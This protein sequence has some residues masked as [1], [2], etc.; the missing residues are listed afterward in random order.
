MRRVLAL[1]LFGLP[2]FA[3]AFLPGTEAA[4]QGDD[5]KRAL[6]LYARHCAVCH[7]DDGRG[8]GSAAYLLNPRPRDFGRGEFRLITTTNGAPTDEDLL[9]VITNGMPGSAMPPWDRLPES[10][11]RL[12]V[13]VVKDLWIKALRKAYEGDE[14]AEE[15]IRQDTTPGT[16]VSYEGEGEPDLSRI[17]LGRIVY[18]QACA[19]CHGLDG[20]GDSTKELLDSQKNP[21]PARDF[22]KGIFKGG[23]EARQVYARLRAGMKGTAMPTFEESMLSQKEAWA[24]V[25]FV[26]TLVPTGAQRLQSQATQRLKIRR[27]R[28]IPSRPEEWWTAAPPAYLALM[29]LWWRDRRVEGVLFQAVH[30]GTTLALRIIWDDTT[31]DQSNL[32]QRDFHDGAAVQLSWDK[33]PPFFGMGDSAA[34]TL[35]WSW[36][37]SWQEDRKGFIDIESIYPGMNLDT[38]YPV[39][40]NLKAGERPSR[41]KVSAPHHDPRYLSGWGAG[42][43]MSD[44]ARP[45]AVEVARAKGLGTMTTQEPGEQ[46]VMGEGVWDRGVWTLTLKAPVPA[47]RLKELF[48]A[49]AVWDGSQGDRNGQKSVT[50]WHRLE[51]E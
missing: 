43:P 13:R 26:R 33:D 46:T 15:Y 18:F 16:A 31:Q 7:G 39:Q 40:K 41:D 25:H 29:P 3:V 50:I 9:R 19:S 35:I 51:L 23:S 12:L 38:Y 48:I 37:A 21:A 24:V 6:E 4:A 47:E 27:A 11:R 1:G 49:F 8:D 32:R 5:S 42:N 20:R 30:D 44:P 45:S 2:W 22:T 17:A 34:S 28:S 14:D 36:K 10:D